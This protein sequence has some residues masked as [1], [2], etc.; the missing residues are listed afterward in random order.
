MIIQI[1]VSSSCKTDWIVS[2]KYSKKPSAIARIKIYS[3]NSHNDGLLHGF[4]LK[5]VVKSL[6]VEPKSEGSFVRNREFFG[7]NIFNEST[8]G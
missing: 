6:G 3:I 4:G 8:K 2:D 5:M 7:E 1:P